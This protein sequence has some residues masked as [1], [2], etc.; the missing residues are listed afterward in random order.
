MDP[1][2]YKKLQDD[3]RRAW[4]EL[5]YSHLWLTGSDWDDETD[6]DDKLATAQVKARAYLEIVDRLSW[7]MRRS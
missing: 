4:E 6:I 7:M 3:L 2:D 5:E 1:I